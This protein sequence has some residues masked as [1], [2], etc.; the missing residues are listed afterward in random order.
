M[1]WAQRLR[2]VF[3]ID[4]ETC[5]RCG[6]AMKIV[7]CIVD[8][9]VIRKLLRRAAPAGPHTQ[10]PPARAPPAGPADGMSSEKNPR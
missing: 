2:R 5:E 8:P 10:P 6:G 3:N 4:I 1:S 7:A 9:A